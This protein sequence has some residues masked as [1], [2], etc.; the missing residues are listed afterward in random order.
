MS[1]DT[2]G[3]YRRDVMKTIGAGA[4]VSVLGGAAMAQEDDDG[5]EGADGDTDDDSGTVHTVQTLIAGPATNPERPADF[6]FQ[7]TGLHVQPGDV[8]KFVFTTPD[9]NVVSYHPAFGMRRRVPVGV[10]AF[11]SPLLGWR[12]DS[13]ADDQ[14]EPPAEPGEGGEEGEDGENGEDGEGGENGGEEETSAPVPSTWLHAFETAGVYDILCSPHEGFGMNLRVVVGDVEEAPFE[15]SNPDNLAPPR[16]GPV[17]LARVTLT[18]PALEPA[19]IVE[20]GRVPWQALSANQ[21]GQ[22]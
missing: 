7:P 8:V 12:A 10:D 4:A 11:S 2:H 6:F 13:I 19:N 16:A 3:P 18:D 20:Q 21:S 22:G 14:I 9:H 15:T 5:D 17:G 1:R